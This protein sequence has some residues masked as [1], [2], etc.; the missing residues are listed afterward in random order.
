MRYAI[1]DFETYS[2]ADLQ[3]VGSLRYAQHSSTD[4][5]CVS[6][7]IVENDA[8]GEIKTWFPPDPIPE[9]ILSIAAD[10]SAL[11]VASNDLFDRSIEHY[12]A[13]PRYSWPIIPLARRRC[14]MAVALSF[15]LP[16]KL[17]RCAAALKFPT[18]KSPGGRRVMLEL[19]K[20]RKAKKDEDPSQIYR[21]E[22]TPEKIAVLAAYN[23]DDVAMTS[24]IIRR[25]GFLSPAEQAV[26][27][28]NERINERGT[29]VDRQ[30]LAPMLRLE[31]EIAAWVRE[32]IGRLSENN[33]SSPAQRDKILAWLR[34]RGCV[35][36]DLRKETVNAALELEDLPDEA[37]E[38]LDVRA[39]GAS[40]AVHK[41]R[42]L[43]AYMGEDGRV[44]PSLRYHGAGPGRFTADNPDGRR[45]PAKSG[46]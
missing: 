30:L 44:C 2:E 42:R 6:F 40:A 36:A 1:L 43:D 3:K 11:V 22:R 8:R 46:N 21:P 26:W 20:P 13:N 34:Q 25:F 38:L 39:K 18:Q 7:C 17:E 4:V 27:E 24:E 28:L 9:E 31:I 35:L 37:R 14:A 10:P 16:A 23:R 33:I 45:S 41:L 29:Y 32:E 12:V 5:N 19:C 15:A